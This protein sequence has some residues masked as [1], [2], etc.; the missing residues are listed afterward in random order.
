MESAG[1]NEQKIVALLAK[2]CGEHFLHPI[3]NRLAGKTFRSAQSDELMRALNALPSKLLLAFRLSFHNRRGDAPAS[4]LFLV[5]VAGLCVGPGM[6]SVPQPTPFGTAYASFFD[7]LFSIDY[8]DPTSRLFGTIL[9]GSGPRPRKC[10]VNRQ[11][12]PMRSFTRFS[13]A[14]ITGSDGSVL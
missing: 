3:A 9:S 1:R 5:S 10:G 2:C 11:E 4:H 7:H 8:G 14:S 13:A 6:W 12:Q